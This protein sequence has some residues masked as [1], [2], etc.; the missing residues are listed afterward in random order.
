MIPKIIHLC[1]LSGDAFPVD[2]VN[3]LKTWKEYL[4][5][6]EIWL[7]GKM[8][9]DCHGLNINEKYFDLDSTIWTRQTYD[10]KKYAFAADYIR[11]Y[12]LFFY[13]GIYL[14][15]DVEV[16][17]PFDDL[18]DLP[19]FIGQE[20]TMSGIEAATI[21]FE[22]GNSLIECLLQRYEKREF[23][24]SDGSFDTQ[25]IPYIIRNCIENGYEYNVIH[26]KDEFLFR[27]DVINVF[28]YDFFSP[29]SY[30]TQL[31]TPTNHTYSIH[32]F[33]A[34]WVAKNKKKLSNKYKNREKYKKYFHNQFLY[35]IRH[36]VCTCNLFSKL[37]FSIYKRDIFFIADNIFVF[38][39]D[40]HK[41]S[42][43]TRPLNK[44]DYDFISWD[45]SNFKDNLSEIYPIVR[46]KENGLEI[47]VVIEREEA[48]PRKEIVKRIMSI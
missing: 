12:A 16:I 1:W 32:H 48:V 24:K 35:L 22:K 3:C 36:L 42:T 41:L 2:I 19:Y 21:G 14:D 44:L 11:L 10:A 29:K 8:P 4:K 20:Q 46:I 6:Y 39:E 37:F 45:K 5:D 34:S 31:I 38:K 7:W 18:L 9:R 17:K 23:L 26:S 30:S 43:L 25:P 15:T 40:F 33:A 47:H 13:G 28:E 27:D